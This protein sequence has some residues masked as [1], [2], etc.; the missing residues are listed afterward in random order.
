MI[1]KSLIAAAA[2]AGTLAVAAPMPAE[3]KTHVNIS[4]GFGVGGYYPGPYGYYDPGY[5]PVYNPGAISCRKGHHIVGWSGFNHV[6]AVDCSLPGYRYTAWRNG[7][8]FV[9]T[10]N[11]FGNIT[12]VNRIF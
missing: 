8:K 9:V 1:A 10:V 11:R 4:I 3:A 7:H 2:L 6:Q 12:N 5:Y